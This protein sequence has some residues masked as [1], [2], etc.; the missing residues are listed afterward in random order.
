MSDLLRKGASGS[1]PEAPVPATSKS[2][3]SAALLTDLETQFGPKYPSDEAEWDELLGTKLSTTIVRS[4]GRARLRRSVGGLLLDQGNLRT[5]LSS[6]S[7]WYEAKGYTN[8]TSAEAARR[9]LR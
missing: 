6:S 7:R 4:H 8:Q 2:T 1:I 3:D 5:F 9:A